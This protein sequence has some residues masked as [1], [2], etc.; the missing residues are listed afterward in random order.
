MRM[1]R[2]RREGRLARVFGKAVVHFPIRT[3]GPTLSE[4]LGND[5]VHKAKD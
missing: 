5:S 1:Q 2:L 4:V 3:L